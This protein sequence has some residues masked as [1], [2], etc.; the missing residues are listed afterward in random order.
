MKMGRY[1]QVTHSWGDSEQFASDVP[2]TVKII[3]VDPHQSL[4]L[5]QHAHRDEEWK[6][7]HGTGAVT[8]GDA[9]T[10]VISGD[11]FFVARGMKHRVEAGAEGLVFVEVA[12]G[13]FDE[14][15]IQRF[16]DRYGR[17]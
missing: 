15:D 1:A 2:C 7:V 3:S 17:V 9:R 10:A 13:A 11:E 6:I 4:S 8:I 12:L 14:N 16:D 5:Q